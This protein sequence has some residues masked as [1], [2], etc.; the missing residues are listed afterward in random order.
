[1]PPKSS[2]SKATS[3]AGEGEIA[4]KKARKSSSKASLGSSATAEITPIPSTLTDDIISAAHK[5]LD[6]AKNG[7]WEELF[8]ALDGQ[9]TLVNV[10]PEVRE[11]AAL[12]Q[13]AY[14]GE[15]SVV[16]T[17][18]N[19]YGADPSR[20][21]KH[22]QTAIEV[23]KEQGQAEVIALIV[24]HSGVV[25]EGPGKAKDIVEPKS[26]KRVTKSPTVVETAGKLE[27]THV[28]PLP[29]ITAF[30]TKSAHLLIDHAKAG[31]WEELFAML[32]KQKE[33]VNVRPDVRDYS[34]LHQAAYHDNKDAMLTLINKYGADP[35][36]LTG[37]GDSLMEVAKSQG[38]ESVIKALEE[39]PSARAPEGEAEMEEDEDDDFEV[40]QMPDGSWKVVQKDGAAKAEVP[41]AP[42]VKADAPAPLAKKRARASSTPPAQPVELAACA[43]STPA[44]TKGYPADFIF[45][46]SDKCHVY[47]KEGTIWHAMLKR[48][49]QFHLMQLIEINLDSYCVWNRWG[50]L[51]TDGEHEATYFASPELAVA[52]F[53]AKF[54]EKTNNK[55]ENRKS[56]KQ[57]FAKYTYKPEADIA[58]SVASSPSSCKVPFPALPMTADVVSQA[59]KLIDLAKAGSWAELFATLKAQKTLVNVRPEVRE[60]SALHQ[61]AY[62]GNAEAVMR[63]IDDCG[64]DPAQCTKFGKSAADIAEEQGFSDVA[65]KVRTRLAKPI[66][67]AGG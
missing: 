10:R 11:Y 20:H 62:Q 8:S 12:H 47:Q 42:A 55:W 33:L 27:P 3:S 25:A 46:S 18:L 54:Y 37:S 40:K 32:D 51:D 24:A 50:K 34:P 65:D 67:V 64:A 43:S 63:L 35:S 4:P 36:L 45:P 61:A 14:H 56:F 16:D 6:L 22:G 19:K 23:A 26:G 2:K 28:V 59:H 66:S 57:F 15:V 5:L 48:A 60:F 53:K 49:N 38:C 1:M 41:I 13:A 39:L 17:L 58:E 52:T 9:P 31:R 30:V 21:T 7:S 29:K 44:A